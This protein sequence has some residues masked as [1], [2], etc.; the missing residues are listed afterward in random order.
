[1]IRR[2]SVSGLVAAS[3]LTPALAACQAN[4]TEQPG[5]AGASASSAPSA[6]AGTSAAK[7]ALLDSTQAI[8]QGN[9][10]FAITGQGVTSRGVVHQPSRSAQLTVAFDQAGGKSPINF[11]LIHVEPESWVKLDLNGATGIPAV[12]NLASGKYLHLDQSRIKDIK[13]LRFDF[14]NV[15]PAGSAVLTRA[16]T[17]VREAGPGAYA[18]T[19]NLDE[20]SEAAMIDPTSLTALGVEAKAVPFTAKVDDQKRL[21]ELV[22]QIPATGNTKAYDLKVNYSDYGAATPAQKPTA[23]EVVEAPAE[24]YDLYR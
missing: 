19:I 24:L 18:G 6:S 1:M 17:D 22:I 20:A 5:G 13:D 7:Q 11:D 9:F 12:D 21:T 16:V 10:R 2:W 4:G 3:L 15:D 8:S 23:T 14:S